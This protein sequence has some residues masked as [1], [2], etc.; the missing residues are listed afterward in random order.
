LDSRL[1]CL[2]WLPVFLIPLGF[3]ASS[4]PLV[5]R[6][7]YLSWHAALF[8]PLAS[9]LPQPPLPPGSFDFLVFQ[10][11][12]SRWLPGFPNH[13]GSQTSLPSFASRRPQ[14]LWLVG[15]PT[16]LACPSSPALA[17]RLHYPPGLQASP[18]PLAARLLGFPWL[19]GF[20]T[21]LAFQASIPSL[22]SRLPQLPW[23]PG[24]SAFLGF[25]A[26]LPPLASRL[27]QLPW[28]PGSFTSLSF[29]PIVALRSQAHRRAE[30]TA[31]VLQ[32]GLSINWPQHKQAPT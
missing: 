20:F 32:A 5:S 6:I 14:L 13:F 8:T 3:Q 25:Q 17:P 10:A 28:R 19:S 27:P 24:V 2:P 11:S 1:V 16:S 23:L 29:Q 22:S 26:A 7:L 9:R 30:V 4:T 12:W 31:W 15:F 18:I 21:F